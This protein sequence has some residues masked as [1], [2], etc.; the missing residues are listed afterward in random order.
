MND[1]ALEGGAPVASGLDPL[2]RILGG[3][4][5]CRRL[6]LIEGRPGSGK[7]TLGLHFLIAGAR[8]GERGLY[9]SLSETRAELEASARSHGLDLA[10][11]EFCELMPPELALN[12]DLEQSVIHPADLELGET[13]QLVMAAV[14]AA[15]PAR[16]VFDS[17][18]EIR[19]LAQ[20]PLRYR[21]QVL[22]LKHFFAQQGCTV[23][24]LD[25]LTA[26][27][28]HV[29]LHSLAHGVIRLEAVPLS[30]GADRRRLRVLKMRT[31]A[32]VGGYHD[33]VIRTGGLRIF[34]RLV[35][36][37]H[38]RTAGEGALVGSDVP[39]LDAMLG[40]GL[41]RGTSTLILGPSGV[42][43]TT[44]ATQFVKAALD[45]GERALFLTFDESKRN[46][47]R[48]NAGLGFDVEEAVRAGQLV[49]RSIDPAEMTPGELT[50][51]ICEEVAAGAAVVVLDSLSGY[52]HAMPE[53]RFLLLQMHE[54]LSYLDGQDVVTLV[55]LAQSGVVGAMTGSV[56]LT[57]LAD[58][59]LLLRFFEAAGEMRRVVS[60]VK[61]RTGSHEVALRELTIGHGGVQVG[62]QL[63][64][65]RG[66][67]SGVPSWSPDG[68]ALPEL[69]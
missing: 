43:K 60:T 16:I 52:Q 68:D 57:Y 19:L 54:L 36:V 38:A 48:R 3:G 22:A 10:G 50:E 61:R 46:F 63:T 27:D 66:I 7:T 29:N 2:D 21:R 30:Y 55:T 12:A 32:F 40:G 69:T 18:S 53:E 13:V 23:L 24:V 39:Q 31:R 14:A 20:H 9:V 67:L 11:I 45:R 64:G 59:V 37:Q 34:P 65:F 1:A 56:D 25:D 17:L 26:E 44:L 6:H 41:D 5:A 58:N 15:R 49:V 33:Y 47:F 42:G 8:R 62:R 35:A 51:L 28:D 4:Y